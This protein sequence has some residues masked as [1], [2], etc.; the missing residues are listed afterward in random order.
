MPKKAKKARRRRD[1]QYEAFRA[2]WERKRPYRRQRERGCGTPGG[3][4]YRPGVSPRQHRTKAADFLDELLWLGTYVGNDC[5]SQAYVAVHE[6]GVIKNRKWAKN[7][8][9]SDPFHKCVSLVARMSFRWRSELSEPELAALA[10]AVAKFDL[11]GATFDAAV[12]RMR[13][14]LRAAEKAGLFPL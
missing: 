10:W 9:V 7:F 13:K 3:M 11:P 4:N 8:G 5:F 2:E 14:A 1:A 12:A 6:T